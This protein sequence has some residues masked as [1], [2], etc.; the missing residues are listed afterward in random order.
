ML[1]L[2]QMAE[3]VGTITLNQPAKRNA[4]SRA[5]VEEVITAFADFQKAGARA[6]VI[7]ATPDAKVWSAGHDVGE[8][9]HGQD[10][11]QYSDPLERLLRAVASSRP[12]SSPWSMD[13]SGAGQPTSS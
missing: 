2:T 3:A 7:R 10:P 5:L 11:L 8:L 6:V 4:L 13:R 12:R 9:P 1:I